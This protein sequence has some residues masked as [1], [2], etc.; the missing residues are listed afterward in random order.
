MGFYKWTFEDEEAQYYDDN[1][2]RDYLLEKENSKQLIQHS[3]ICTEDAYISQEE[4]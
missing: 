2:L 1:R 3:G 4:R